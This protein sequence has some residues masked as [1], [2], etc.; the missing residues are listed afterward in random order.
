[1]AAQIMTIKS[2]GTEKLGR[3]GKHISQL[4]VEDRGGQEWLFGALNILVWRVQKS[5]YKGHITLDQAVD[6]WLL[7]WTNLSKQSCS[8]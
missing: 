3:Q 8:V 5:D 6:H 2:L 7:C 1:M 4:Q